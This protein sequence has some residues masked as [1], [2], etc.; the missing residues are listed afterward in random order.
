MDLNDF[1]K[2]ITTRDRLDF[3]S[4]I[5]GDASASVLS[6]YL[7]SNTTITEINLRCN[8]IGLSGASALND[9][10]KL[11]NSRNTLY[12]LQLTW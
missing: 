3:C 11:N 2:S 10:L 1:L 8:K 4:S 6:E 5:G 12:F 7:K 9:C